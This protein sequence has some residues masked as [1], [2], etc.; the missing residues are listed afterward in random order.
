MPRNMEMLIAPMIARV[1]AAF[2]ACGRRKAWTPSAIASTPV[3][4]V[5]PEAKARKIRNRARAN[6][7]SSGRPAEVAW[8]QWLRHRANPTARVR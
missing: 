8:G 5:A 3:S 7:G 6:S 4:A 2:L 1:A